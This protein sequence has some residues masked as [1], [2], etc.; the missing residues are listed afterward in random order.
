[1]HPAF[2]DMDDR[3]ANQAK[4]IDTFLRLGSIVAGPVRCSGFRPRTPPDKVPQHT[5]RTRR[6]D[7]RASVARSDALG[8]RH[9][10]GYGRVV[11]AVE[12]AGGGPVWER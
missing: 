10:R 3:L 2:V 4:F 11:T 12:C 9:G 7:D 1:M 5:R 6:P 8:P